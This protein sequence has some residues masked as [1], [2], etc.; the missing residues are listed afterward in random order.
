MISD[1]SPG[2]EGLEAGLALLCSLSPGAVALGVATAKLDTVGDATCLKNEW[3]GLDGR[4][5]GAG[6][7][8]AMVN[9]QSSSECF[10]STYYG[11][12]NI[13]SARL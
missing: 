5:Q 3:P 10:L 2:T 1:C 11:S 4:G 8:G 12:D 9:D 6:S 13:P 7:M